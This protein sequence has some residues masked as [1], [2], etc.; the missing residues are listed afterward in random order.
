MQFIKDH[1][2]AIMI[3]GLLAAYVTALAIIDLAQ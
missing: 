3:A 2:R 1:W